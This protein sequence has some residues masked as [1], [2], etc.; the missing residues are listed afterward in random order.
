MWAA[1][2]RALAVFGAQNKICRTTPLARKLLIIFLVCD[3]YVLY[4]K[5]PLKL[6]RQPAFGELRTAWFTR[7]QGST[8][9]LED[10]GVECAQPFIFSNLIMD[11]EWN[12]AGWSALLLRRYIHPEAPA[13]IGRDQQPDARLSHCEI[14]H[15]AADHKVDLT[16]P[17][18]LEGR[19][20]RIGDVKRDGD[21]SGEKTGSQPIHLSRQSISR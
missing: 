17:S 1:G 19:R 13:R 15:T 8:R 9:F 16:Q 10:G 2:G 20:S 7:Y 14:E 6:G 4:I 3:D 11:E 12:R 21:Q 18:D 5:F